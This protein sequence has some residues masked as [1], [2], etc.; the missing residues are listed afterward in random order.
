MGNAHTNKKS[1]E[2]GGEKPFDMVSLIKVIVVLLVMF[3]LPVFYLSNSSYSFYSPN[4]ASIKVAFQHTGKRIANCDEADVIKKEGERYREILKTEKRIKMNMGRL[5][6]CPRERFPV[7]VELSVDGNIM[8]D[9]AYKPAGI[10]K[11]MA[12]YAYDE[13][14]VKPGAHRI[15]AGLYDSGAKDK[16]DFTIEETVDIK[17]R[18]ILLLRFDNATNKLVLE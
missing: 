18:Q 12:S 1:V 11:D 7:I 8:L 5:S 4:D 14:I 3:A 16:P 17:P 2:A 9:R 15:S 13:F 10:K 6:G